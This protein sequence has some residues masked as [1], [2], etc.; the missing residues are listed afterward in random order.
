MSS[1]SDQMIFCFVASVDLRAG[2]SSASHWRDPSLEG[3]FSFVIRQVPTNSTL[4]VL[5]FNLINIIVAVYSSCL[6]STIFI[7]KDLQNL[8]KTKS[9]LAQYKGKAYVTYRLSCG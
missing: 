8:I 6:L 3:R 4:Q 9:S 7:D 5:F 2:L 1:N